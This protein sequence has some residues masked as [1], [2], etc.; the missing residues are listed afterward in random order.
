MKE[1][2]NEELRLQMKQFRSENYN[3]NIN[4]IA[5]ACNMNYTQFADWLRGE[6]NFKKDTLGRIK[7]FLNGKV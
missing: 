5:E 6:R 4:K 1:Q 7:K 3:P 2:L